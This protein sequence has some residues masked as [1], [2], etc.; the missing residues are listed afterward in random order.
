ME[1]E[2]TKSTGLPSGRFSGR[3]AFSQLVRDA[4]GSAARDGWPTIIL[5][6][7]T[8]EDWPLRERSVVE[9]LHA[10]S[11]SGRRLIM[12]ANRYD[13]VVRNHARFV[14]WRQT[15]GHIIDCRICRTAA[16]ADFPSAIW[17][18]AWFMHRLDPLH[19]G[20]V[21]GDE[22]E[23]LVQLR[24]LLDEHWRNSSPGFPSSTLGL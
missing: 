22:P 6:D 4:L 11:T 14:S 2:S 13:E 21:C 12:L 19:S 17:S 9:S 16:P 18:S 8:F 1:S 20:G 24:E 10:W 23:R 15:W 7:A 3:E 5:S